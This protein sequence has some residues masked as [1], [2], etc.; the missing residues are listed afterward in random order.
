MFKLKQLIVAPILYFYLQL[1][2]KCELM[3]EL[4]HMNSNHP[5]PE[6]ISLDKSSSGVP[7][8]S[9]QLINFW[10]KVVFS[11]FVLPVFCLQLVRHIHQGGGT[12]FWH[13]AYGER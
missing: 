11:L 4:S 6:K 9:Q 10:I 12:S 1:V 7:D 8:F 2:L 5:K 3:F 13:P